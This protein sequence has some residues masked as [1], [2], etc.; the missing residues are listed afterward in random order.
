MRLRASRSGPIRG[1]AAI[2]GDKSLSHRAL[3]LGALAKGETRI[4]GLLEAGDVMATAAALR[5]FGIDVEKHEGAWIVRGG[6][7]KSPGE[8]IDCGNSGTTAR[9]LM[10]AAAGFDLTATF[11]GDRS[12]RRRPMRRVIEPL[13]R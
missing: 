10:G 1:E 9:L 7:W 4:A 13:G 2:P 5:A 3:M 11:T 8:A 6:Q 12:L